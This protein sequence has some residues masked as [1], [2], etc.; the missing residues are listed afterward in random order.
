MKWKPCPFCLTDGNEVGLYGLWDKFDAGWI[1]HI[2][3]THCGA[4]GPSVYSET[5]AFNALDRAAKAWNMRNN[6]QASKQ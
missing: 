3:C 4:D 6:P 1:A 2:H 5:D